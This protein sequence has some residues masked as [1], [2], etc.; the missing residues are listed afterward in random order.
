M[1]ITGHIFNPSLPRGSQRQDIELTTPNKTYSTKQLE[2]LAVLHQGKTAK[3]WFKLHEVMRHDFGRLLAEKSNPSKTK[4]TL[5]VWDGNTKQNYLPPRTL[6]KRIGQVQEW[7]AIQ[8]RIL[9]A[10]KLPIAI[11]V[12]STVLTGCKAVEPFI[13]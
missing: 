3:D 11:I 1:K 10:R 9:A 4:L 7:I 8:L 6:R 13:H 12:A 5:E 2:R